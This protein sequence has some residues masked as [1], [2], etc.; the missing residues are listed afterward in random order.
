MLIFFQLILNINHKISVIE[1]ECIFCFVEEAFLIFYVLK[2]FK[3][4]KCYLERNFIT[5][6]KIVKLI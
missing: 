3:E 5:L 4:S 6:F 2:I 1:L